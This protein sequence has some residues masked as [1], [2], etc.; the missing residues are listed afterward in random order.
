MWHCRSSLRKSL[1]SAAFARKRFQGAAAVAT[2]LFGLPCGFSAS[3]FAPSLWNRRAAAVGSGLVAGIATAS[4]RASSSSAQE[5]GSIATAWPES[6]VDAKG[7]QVSLASLQ[8]ESV[9]LY[10]AGEWCP[11]CR[12]FTPVLKAFVEANPGRR[13]IFISSDFSAEEYEHHRGSMGADWLAL[14][15]NAPE[16]DALKQKHRLWGGREAPKFGK[17]RRGGLPA[18]VVVDPSTGVELRYL[19]AESQGAK[20]LLEW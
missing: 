15:Y 19:D 9:A 8:G 10:F 14:P 11:M 16:Q 4:S 17:D 13:V 18:L 3:G 7:Q 2:A 20:A 6:A 1:R 12:D 5:S